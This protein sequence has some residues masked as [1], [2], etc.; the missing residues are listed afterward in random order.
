MPGSNKSGVLRVADGMLRYS[1]DGQDRWSLRVDAIR[2]I[3]E[4]TT[5]HGPFADDY[6]LV[7]VAGAPP[8]RYS[9]PMYAQTTLI[10]ELSV[11]LGAQLELGLANRTDFAS[12][13]AWPEKM[14]DKALL[15]HEPI[16]RGTGPVNRVRDWLM[17]LVA[18]DFTDEVLDY[19]GVNGAE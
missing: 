6:F 1:C 11:Y 14:Q 8:E 15:T 12:R 16:R 4:H 17:P 18:E 9:A 10:T 7:F 5:D 2:L 3:G 19:L 13:V